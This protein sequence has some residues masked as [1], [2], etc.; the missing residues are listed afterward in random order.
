MGAIQKDHVSGT[1]LVVDDDSASGRSLNRLLS[2]QGYSVTVTESGKEALSILK[3][4][5]VD[6]V[7]LD[8]R[9]PEM[10]GLETCMHIRGNTEF[11]RI[12]VIF[13][14]GHDDQDARIA[15]IKAGGDDFLLKPIDD[16]MLAVRVQNLMLVRRYYQHIERERASLK[17]TVEEQSNL[18]SRAMVE[19]GKAKKTLRRF[20]E[21]IIFRLSKA[22]EFRDDETGNHVQRMSRY[23]GLIA[24]RMGMSSEMS[25]AV[26]IASALHDVGKISIPDD[27]LRKPGRLDDEEMSMMRQHAEKGYRV[28]TGSESSLLELAATI[29]WSHHERFDGTGYPRRLLGKEIPFEG[30]IAAVADVFD[31]LTSKRVYKSAFTIKQ[32]TDIITKERGTGFDPQIVDTFVNNLDAVQNV[33]IV[34]ADR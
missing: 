16:T 9:M 33:M 6:V 17:Q 19:I 7:I 20:N 25:D 28:L 5:P 34:Y 15:G 11:G 18:L 26:R 30:R 14:T 21:E 1:I 3:R 12:P 8:V 2:Q 23:C 4:N 27:I 32:A 22:V 29:A 10:D 24:L 13:I 31:A